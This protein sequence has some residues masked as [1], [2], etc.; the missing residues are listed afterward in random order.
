[1]K[2]FIKLMLGYGLYLPYQMFFSYVAGP[3][4]I[5]VLVPGGLIML[6]AIGRGEVWQIYKEELFGHSGRPKAAPVE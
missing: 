5:L 1:M 4:L 2:S 3:L 6:L